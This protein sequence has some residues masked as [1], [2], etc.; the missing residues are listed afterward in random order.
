MTFRTE[1]EGFHTD[2]MAAVRALVGMTSRERGGH[3]W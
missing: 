3:E 2:G 1:R